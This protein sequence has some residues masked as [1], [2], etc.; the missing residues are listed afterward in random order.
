LHRCDH[1][2]ALQQAVQQAHGKRV[3]GT[4]RVDLVGGN[5]INMHFAGGSVR[6]RAIAA[7]RHH[8]PLE[9][10]TSYRADGLKHSCRGD[11]AVLRF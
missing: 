9:P 3:T 6:I 4:C 1:G 8:H 11:I 2:V 7:S 10:V 5:G